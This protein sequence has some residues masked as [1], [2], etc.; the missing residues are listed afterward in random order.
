MNA[1]VFKSKYLA[2]VAS[3]SWALREEVG[4]ESD[5]SGHSGSNAPPR[6]RDP[7]AVHVL[8][9]PRPGVGGMP[10]NKHPGQREL[11]R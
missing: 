8:S 4:R 1:S 11:M 6:S 3:L 5:G 10:D 9:L 7:R 2:S